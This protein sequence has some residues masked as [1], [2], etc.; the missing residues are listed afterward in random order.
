MEKWGK[1][2]KR[3]LKRPKLL[4]NRP[5]HHSNDQSRWRTDQTT[6]QTTKAANETAKSPPH[7]PQINFKQQKKPESIYRAS[8]IQYH[9]LEKFASSAD[10]F[11]SVVL[12]NPELSFTS[13]ELGETSKWF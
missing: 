6:A 7:K 4:A 8:F 9:Y 13:E 10:S 11:M 5:N 3:Q 1:R 2:P 12:L